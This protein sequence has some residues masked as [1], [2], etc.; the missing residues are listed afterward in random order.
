MWLNWDMIGTNAPP[1]QVEVDADHPDYRYHDNLGQA[2]SPVGVNSLF[3]LAGY[4]M[5]LRRAHPALR[6]QAYGDLTI[7]DGDVSY[8]FS[9]PT[10]HPPG[11]DLVGRLLGRRR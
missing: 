1:Q 3:V 9:A 11:T 6:Q 5:T 7:G 2:N 10:G 8:L 4:L